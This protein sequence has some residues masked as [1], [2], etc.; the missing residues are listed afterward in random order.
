[1]RKNINQSIVI[2][3]LAF[4]TSTICSVAGVDGFNKYFLVALV[5]MTVVATIEYAKG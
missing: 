5:P 2:I 1:M 3:G 4:I